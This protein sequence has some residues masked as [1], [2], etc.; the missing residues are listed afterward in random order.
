MVV[1]CQALNQA[2]AGR[3][4]E[5]AKPHSHDP[6]SVP[7]SFVHSWG[8]ALTVPPPPGP[9]CM[10][11]RTLEAL[12][13]RPLVGVTRFWVPCLQASMPLCFRTLDYSAPSS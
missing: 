12:P 10:A 2:E 6:T 7:A 9:R 4:V 3:R 5:H 13:I 1:E 8:P 11:P